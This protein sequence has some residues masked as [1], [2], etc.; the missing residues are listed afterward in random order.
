MNMVYKVTQES[1]TIQE[2]MVLQ[3]A[4]KRAAFC[5]IETE[6][7]A[8]VILQFSLA[9]SLFSSGEQRVQEHGLS[10][11]Q[12]WVNPP[13]GCGGVFRLP[14]TLNTK[15]WLERMAAMVFRGR[16]WTKSSYII[17]QVVISNATK[18]VPIIFFSTMCLY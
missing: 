2:V 17:R 15:G 11:R 3:V 5:S 9:W 14:Q 16:S 6:K 10:L 7:G 1:A 12:D 18:G 8:I 4:L 13:G